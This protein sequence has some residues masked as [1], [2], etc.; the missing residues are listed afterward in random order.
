MQSTPGV[1]RITGR[2][3]RLRGKYTV[4]GTT[5]QLCSRRRSSTCWPESRLDG[6]TTRALIVGIDFRP[7]FPGSKSLE[8]SLWS[9]C[10][11]ALENELPEQQFNTWVRP[12]QSLEGDDALRL[13]APNRFVVDWVRTNLIARIGPLLRERGI[14]EPA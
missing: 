6:N 2:S 3:R 4:T 12:L 11:R 8:A 14:A 13:L 10:V 5:L 1:L 9:R 7:F